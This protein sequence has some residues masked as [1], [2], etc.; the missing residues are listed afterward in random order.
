VPL[1][2]SF[3]SPFS[4]LRS[5]DA[6]DNHPVVDSN[7]AKVEAK[8]AKEEER[9]F[10]IHLP[11]FLVYFISGLLL[12]PIQSAVPKGKGR[13]CIDCTN[14]PDG[15]KTTSSANTFIL[16]PSTGDA[17]ACPPVYYAMACMRHLQHLW[18]M[19][20]TFPIADILQHCDDINAAFCRVLYTLEL[21]IAFA[22]VFRIFLLIPIGQ[23]F[24]SRSV[25][26]YFSL[27]SDIQAYVLTCADLITSR[28]MHPLA[29][30]ACLPPEPMPHELLALVDAINQPMSTQECASHSNSTFVDDN[31]ILAL[32]SNIRGTLHNSVVAAFLLFGWP[33]EDWQSSWLAPDKWE[34]DAC[35]AM[36]YLVFLICSR[37]LRVT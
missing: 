22:Y 14:G 25:P 20:I 13:I 32:P 5:R 3:D 37:T 19:R 9:S 21:A 26:S 7:L 24:G 35:S 17:D 16:S 18:R 2:G 12:N 15:A 27:L 29:A 30:A 31:G 33:H 1:R 28:L 11:W 4:A 34:R 10:H 36:L 8:F 23:V 6:C